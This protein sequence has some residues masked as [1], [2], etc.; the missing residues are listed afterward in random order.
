MN[1][2]THWESVY[3]STPVT[4]LGWYQ[5]EPRLS[6]E[7]IRAHAP[8]R[9]SRILDAGGGASSLADR[10][11]EDGYMNLTVLDLSGHALEQARKRLGPEA[12]RV[13]WIEANLLEADLPAAGFDLWHDRAAF[14]FLVDARDR[15]RYVEQAKRVLAPGG[16]LIVAAYALH[17][18]ER[19]SGLPVVRSSPGTL[20]DELGPAFRLVADRVEDHPAGAGTIPFTYAVF[21]TR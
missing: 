12:A 20:Q 5:P 9:A 18:P 3:G 19:C 4:R 1:A 21:Q 13:T 2:K 6:L 11:L 16:H 17:G 8:D 10:L 7:L 15:E 14:H